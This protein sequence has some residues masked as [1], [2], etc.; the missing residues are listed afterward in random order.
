MKLLP[1]TS[2]TS[3]LEED[4]RM[5]L[6]LNV[7]LEEEDGDVN[8]ILVE[9]LRKMDLD[10]NV[11][12]EEEEEED[13]NVI[14]EEETVA[15]LEQIPEEETV[16]RRQHIDMPE[17]DKF[18]AYIALKALS[19]HRPVEKADKE[20]VAQ[21]LKVCLRTI[22][23]IWKQALDMEKQE[24]EVDFSN[25]RKG[26][27]GRKRKDLHLSERVPQIELNKR[28]TLRALARSLDVPYSTLQRR[29][30]WGDLRRHT[31]SLKPFQS[32]ENKIKRLK[33]CISMIDETTISKAMPS[34]KSMENIIHID[35][36]WFDMT[37]RN[38]TYYL[39]P[40]EEDPLRTVQNKNNIG[41]QLQDT[42]PAG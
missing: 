9:E 20:L 34:F 18:A 31:S 4:R 1:V 21:L 3:F 25:K 40:E 30:T 24:Q 15:Q 37:K 5:D 13:V 26:N 22:E 8:I 29:L 36:K 11:R 23:K 19:N 14:L 16:A 38:R 27:C 32:A 35:E 41:R 6:D 33:F 42:C 28:G 17:K 39:L 12:L 7:R 10:L 2:R